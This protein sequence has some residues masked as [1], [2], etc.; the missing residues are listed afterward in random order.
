[1]I[2]ITIALILIFIAQPAI[3]N[4]PGVEYINIPIPDESHANEEI[5]EVSA[6]RRPGD[7]HAGMAFFAFG[8]DLDF[9]SNVEKTLDH[10][11]SLN[12]NSL[13]FSFPV[14]Q[15]DWRG[16]DPYVDKNRTP[17]DENIIFFIR[18]AKQRGFTVM[19]R[20]LLDESSFINDGKWR[21]LIEPKDRREWFQSY[22]D[23]VLRYAEI[24][25]KEGAEILNIGTEL[26]SLE[27][28]TGM[29]TDMVNEIRKIYD[30]KLTYSVNWHNA[31]DNDFSWNI[32]DFIS[33]DAFFPKEELGK[34]ATTE[35][36]IQAWKPWIEEVK[37]LKE[38][39]DKPVVFT[40][41][42]T[43]SQA[44]SFSHSWRPEHGTETDMEAQE[45]YYKATLESLEAVDGIY[46]WAVQANSIEKLEDPGFS[47]LNKP[48]EEVIRKY[49]QNIQR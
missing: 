10:L 32:V 46:W 14:F 17:T 39:H 34:E 5:I 30:G 45:R 37:K 8:N 18:Q 16:T 38:E 26:S 19:I 35:E 41:V 48:A 15:D 31:F 44:G 22:S 21:G 7:F 33:I 36:M 4:N 43:V 25:Q 6:P 24:A 3:A 47:P 49:Y 2:K 9:R 27:R 13:S 40:E 12:V 23:I 1:M 28:E 20:P 11:A 42:G 29:W